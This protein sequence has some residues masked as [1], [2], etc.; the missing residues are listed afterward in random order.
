MLDEAVSAL[1]NLGYKPAEA[2][3]AVRLPSGDSAESEAV[4]TIIRQS[5]ALDKNA[6]PLGRIGQ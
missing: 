4:G 6:P 2:K 1:V 3:R 5:L